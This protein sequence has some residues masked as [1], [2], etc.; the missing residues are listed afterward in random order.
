MD[1]LIEIM[2]I[3]FCYGTLSDEGKEIANK[4][5]K[6][7]LSLQWLDCGR[8]QIGGH[9]LFGDNLIFRIRPD[10]TPE[11]EVVRCEVYESGNTLWFKRDA[12]D[13]RLHEAIFLKDL[14]GCEYN[15]HWVSTEIR[16]LAGSNAP[17]E[18][19]KYV[20]FAK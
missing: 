1:N 14:I 15:S 4:L 3:A 6:D 12:K 20:L 8:W 18:Y 16:Q 5:N 11:P 7:D 2:K 9:W 13:Y 10:Y 17:A 19:P